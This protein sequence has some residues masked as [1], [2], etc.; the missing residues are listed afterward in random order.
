MEEL[1]IRINDLSDLDEITL[2]NL[3]NDINVHGNG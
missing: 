2:C 1:K 3:L